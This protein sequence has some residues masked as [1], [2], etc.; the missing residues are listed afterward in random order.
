[1]PLWEPSFLH[2]WMLAV[3]GFTGLGVYGLV[4]GCVMGVDLGIV[5]LWGWLTRAVCE[6][7]VLCRGL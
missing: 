1:M 5:A 7:S 2:V 4:S 3:G 6:W